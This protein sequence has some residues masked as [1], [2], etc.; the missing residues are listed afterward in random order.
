MIYWAAMLLFQ[1]PQALDL[2]VAEKNPYTSPA[3]IALGKKLFAARC[4]GCHG[5]GG[6]GGKGANLAVS[7]LPRATDDRSL[8]RI[9]RYGLPETEMPG[10]NMAPSEIWQV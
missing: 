7:I 5:P 3:D 1:L 8:Y 6:D 2:P 9:I 4:A 10:L